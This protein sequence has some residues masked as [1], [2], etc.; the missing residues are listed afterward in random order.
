MKAD[1][2]NLI[3]NKVKKAGELTVSDIQKEVDISRQAIHKHLKRLLE[4]GK[5]RKIGST[6]NVG[7]LL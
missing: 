7:F 4:D 2:K 1:I 3:L 5:I 6:R